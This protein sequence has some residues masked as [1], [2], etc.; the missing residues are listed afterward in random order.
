M[1]L[2]LT[3]FHGQWAQLWVDHHS[4]SNSSQS[5]LSKLVQHLTEL[6]AKTKKRKKES[7]AAP[8]RA[9]EISSQFQDLGF[10]KSVFLWHLVTDLCLRDDQVDIDTTTTAS[11]SSKNYKLKSSIR[12]LSNYVMYL[13]VKCKAMVTVYDIDSLNDT[14][15]SMLGNFAFVRND[16][17]VDRSYILQNIRQH[18][19]DCD[20]FGKA[21]RISWEFLQMGKEE[22][23]LWD[24]IAMVWVE[25]L[26]YIAFNCDAAFHTK[27]LCAGGE[28]VTHVKM[29]LLILD[30][31]F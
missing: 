9:P 1:V 30:F 23:G 7:S 22:D 21:N 28:F 25:M 26:C 15:Q 16:Q 19:D 24:L 27:Q 12:E 5:R 3:K 17:Q 10:V 20:V 8:Q 4:K 14:R 6:L 13:L 11:S 29:L 18:H 2:D 31:S